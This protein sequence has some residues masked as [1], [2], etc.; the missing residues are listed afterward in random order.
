M[1]QK[2][3]CWNTHILTSG[4]WPMMLLVTTLPAGHVYAEGS[5]WGTPR[6]CVLLKRFV[7]D[8]EIW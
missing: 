8:S 1:K 5:M 3:P 2:G 4:F 6:S 7:G